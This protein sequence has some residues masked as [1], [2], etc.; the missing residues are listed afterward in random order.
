MEEV[1]AKYRLDGAAAME[2]LRARLT[3]AGA[4]RGAVEQERNVLFDRPD[5]A[6]RQTNQVLRL[7]TLNGGPVGRLTYKGPAAY[8]GVVKRRT[9]LEVAVDDCQV[10]RALLEA[11]GY[12]PGL[13][14]PKQRE[15][16]YLDGAEVALDS[17]PFG[18]YCEIEGPPDV[19]PRVADRL[20]LPSEAAEPLGYPTLM[21]RHLQH[22]RPSGP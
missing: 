14:Y 21:A 22:A 15:T 5:G 8:E 12:R 9:E 17:L 13:E 1:E 10:T 2:R 11:L 4:R 18:T 3:A 20:D 6:L 16:W 7:R 19:V